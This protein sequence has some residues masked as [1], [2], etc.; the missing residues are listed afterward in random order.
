[1]RS[2][3]AAHGWAWLLAA[4]VPLLAAQAEAQPDPLQRTLQQ[5]V[6]EFDAGRFVE[7]QA[8]FREA[9]A[10]SPSART[11]RALGMVAF[12]LH[13]YAACVSYL[14][15]ALASTVKPLDASLRREA[16]AVLARA[17]KS[18]ARVVFQL[19]PRDAQL[20]VDEAPVLVSEGS[21]VA[22]NPGHH[23]IAVQ[24]A[25]R[26]PLDTEIVL[27]PGEE[28]VLSLAL[29]PE[30]QPRGDED[31]RSGRPL[32]KNPW[33]WTGVGVLVVGTVTGLAVGLSR[34]PEERP[35]PAVGGDTGAVLTGP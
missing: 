28:R 3:L 4:L 13:D 8:H 12:E 18:V 34:D 25:G 16:K 2:R 21:P 10:L 20:R 29:A 5:A 35:V 19:S 9:H 26:S 24:A 6:E 17:E 32:Y 27:Q 30:A 33:L 7:A 15:Q 31:A 11:L 14:E 1:T 22:L 23:V